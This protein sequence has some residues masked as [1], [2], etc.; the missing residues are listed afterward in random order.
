MTDEQVSWLS[1]LVDGELAHRNTLP[2]YDALERDPAL[3]GAWERYH[4]IGQVLRGERVRREGRGVAAAVQEQL[5]GEPIPMLPRTAAGCRPRVWYSPFAGAA[6]AAAA[7]L[8]AVFAVPGLY[9]GPE[10]VPDL[11]ESPAVMSAAALTP[12]AA[13]EV[14]R[15]QTDRDDLASKLDLFFVN[16]Q[17]SAPATG[18]KGM[19]PYATLVGYEAGR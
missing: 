16:H 12:P 15:W 6:L 8:L 7:A 1:A 13:R 19:L 18:V 17:E 10:S 11:T 3:R 2:L 14:R 5:H 9:Q 4:L